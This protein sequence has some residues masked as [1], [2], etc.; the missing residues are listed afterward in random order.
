MAD[1]ISTLHPENRPLDDL[2]PNILPDNI[3]ADAVST[4]RIQ[5]LAVTTPKIANGA[6]TADK[7]KNGEVT[8]NKI[9][10][11]FRQFIVES[12]NSI[13]NLYSNVELRLSTIENIIYAT[14]V[15]DVEYIIRN[16]TTSVSPTNIPTPRGNLRVF[17]NSLFKV[18]A[19]FG[20][21]HGSSNRFDNATAVYRKGEYSSFYHKFEKTAT[22]I[23][24]DTVQT[25]TD[26]PIYVDLDPSLIGKEITISCE[27]TT[28]T[29]YIRRVRLYAF[30]RNVEQT[31]RS[32]TLSIT[33]VLNSNTIYFTFNTNQPLL[34][35]D[36]GGATFENI[37]V[38]L[39]SVDRGYTPFEPSEDTQYTSITIGEETICELE[40]PSVITENDKLEIREQG[41]GFYSMILVRDYLTQSPTD[42]IL[43]ENLLLEEV[44]TFVPTASTITLNG[45]PLAGALEPD[46]SFTIQVEKPIE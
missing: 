8:E 21:S 40:T 6:I 3:P 2:Y 7:I 9:A 1:I 11:I 36:Y 29:R 39:G 26:I 13:R 5:N 43:R 38:N 25:N 22:G 16:L 24:V 23:S 37:R 18:N 4:A 46:V 33:G 17:D 44:A 42:V 28:P 15:E 10:P 32:G 30:G 34:S 19:I 12:V 41:G 27:Y 20:K 35:A 31:D 14:A 45:N